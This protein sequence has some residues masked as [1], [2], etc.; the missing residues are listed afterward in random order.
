MKRANW[1]DNAKR[2]SIA[3]QLLQS[4]LIVVVISGIGAMLA[5]GIPNEPVAAS[6]DTPIAFETFQM[7]STH[8]IETRLLISYLGRVHNDETDEFTLDAWEYIVRANIGQRG[9]IE[10]YTCTDRDTA[11]ELP[12]VR[13]LAEYLDAGGTIFEDG[14]CNETVVVR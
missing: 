7:L 5:L 11:S 4:V 6:D 2:S 3:V 12:S 13:Y 8:D 1:N 14:S 9:T 10:S